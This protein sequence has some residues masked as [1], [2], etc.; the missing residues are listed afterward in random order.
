MVAATPVSGVGVSSAVA[1]APAANAVAGTTA[2]TTAGGDEAWPAAGIAAAASGNSATAATVAPT[3]AA[4]GQIGVTV[5][6]GKTPRSA[7]AGVFVDTG[8]PAVAVPWE[9]A[10]KAKLAKPPS[11]TAAVQGAAIQAMSAQRNAQGQVG[12][13]DWWDVCGC[14]N[15]KHIQDIQAFDAVLAEYGRQ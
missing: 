7:V 4:G 10:R 15:D 2:G 8:R 12:V 6:E 5:A 14:Q 3:A 13:E 1:T 9:L 11:S